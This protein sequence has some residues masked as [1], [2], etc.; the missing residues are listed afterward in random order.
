[1]GPLRYAQGG[2][3]P[4]SGNQEMPVLAHG[5]EVIFSQ[6]DYQALQQK[7]DTALTGQNSP[8]IESITVPIYLDNRL[9][10]T[11]VIDDIERR[12]RIRGGR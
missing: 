1:M 11:Q 8:V 10:T 5:G 9:I 6:S 7:L 2:I 3:V 4:G 12:V